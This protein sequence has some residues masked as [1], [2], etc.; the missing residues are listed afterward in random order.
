ML[1]AIGFWARFSQKILK[2]LLSGHKMGGEKLSIAAQNIEKSGY[3][4]QKS[5]GSRKKAIFNKKGS[6]SAK[7]EGSLEGTQGLLFET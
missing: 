5:E 6:F 3:F 4:C 2:S 7:M 1:V